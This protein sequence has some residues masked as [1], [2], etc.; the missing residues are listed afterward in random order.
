ML[1][2][3][4]N[5]V[6]VRVPSLTRSSVPVTAV[7]R[8]CIY[9]PRNRKPNLARDRLTASQTSQT[10]TPKL[11]NNLQKV[12]M[13]IHQRRPL[14]PHTKSNK[15]LDFGNCSSISDLCWQNP[16]PNNLISSLTPNHLFSNFQPY[17]YDSR[18]E[19]VQGSQ[20]WWVLHL[21]TTNAKSCWS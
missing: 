20:H 5:V 21:K 19:Q 13:I 1:E 15:Q 14:N 17:R 12:E 11:V 18:I 10:Q 7:E 3:W 6:I 9:T 2:L 8:W 16:H 4:K